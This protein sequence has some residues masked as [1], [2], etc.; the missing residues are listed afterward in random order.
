MIPGELDSDFFFDRCEIP[1][2]PCAFPYGPCSSC[3]SSLH[4]PYPCC[5]YGPYPSSDA[6]DSFSVAVLLVVLDSLCGADFIAGGRCTPR[7]VKPETIL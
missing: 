3:G 2:S 1:D 6:Y 5:G 4:G 7:S